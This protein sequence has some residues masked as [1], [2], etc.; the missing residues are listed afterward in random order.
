MHVT[1]FQPPIQFATTPLTGNYITVHG[2]HGETIK[3]QSNAKLRGFNCFFYCFF[4]SQCSPCL[5]GSILFDHVSPKN[6]CSTSSGA[7][8]Y[9][10]GSI[11]QLARPWLRLRIAL[12]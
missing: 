7:R 3:V 8:A 10:L 4:L 11:E 9:V 2:G 5:R 12:E 1:I 6:F